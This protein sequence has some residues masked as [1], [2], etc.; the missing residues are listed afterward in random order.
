MN[1]Y[2]QTL[3]DSAYAA[4][5]HRR[6]AEAWTALGFTI[7]SGWRD[8]LALRFMAHL[9]GLRGN[10]Q[11]AADL[12]AAAVVI[13]PDSATGHSHLADAL[14]RLGR[15]R[16][17]E[18]PYRRAIELDHG[19]TEAYG[20]LAR[21]LHLSNR[22]REALAVAETALA[23]ARDRAHAHR[24]LGT[25]LVW[26]NRHEEAI[27]QFRAAQAKDPDDATARCHEGMALLA[28]GRFNP[29][30]ELYEARRMASAVDTAFRDLPQP[31]WHGDADIRGQTILLHA[32][33][34]LGD[35][36]QFVRY[37][38]L[39]AECGASVWLE[40]SPRLKPLVATMPG[41]AGVVAWGEPL[42]D[43]ALHCPLLSLPMAFGTGPASIPARVPYLQANTQRAAAWRQRLGAASRRRIGIAWSGNPSHPDDVLRSIPLDCLLPLLRR[44]DCE[45]HVVQTGVTTSDAARLTQLGVHVHSD[46]PFDFAETAALMQSLDLVIS[47]DSALAH[48]A[49]ALGRPTWLLLQS[50]ADWRWMR[51]RLDTPWYPTMR[52]FRQ[53]GDGDWRVVIG[54]AMRALG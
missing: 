36:I 28:L 53:G 44:Q 49:G 5:R 48:L 38:P 2:A 20:G 50:S 9:E 34:G 3:L 8:A 29:G 37:A 10:T 24:M 47:V 54:D 7:G 13:E 42:P 51:E 12:L 18:L 30:W 25:A 17:A 39:V 41:I 4:Y 16:E 21:V 11:A 14:C 1:T 22:D 45:F 31:M 52:L 23:Q 27:E 46:A 6:Y 19:V 40:V 15:L 26:L 35:A 43:C 33:Q 32:E